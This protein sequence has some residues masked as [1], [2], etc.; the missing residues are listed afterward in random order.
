MRLIP[1]VIVASSL[2]VVPPLWA[3][4]PQDEA[5][6]ESIDKGLSLLEEGARLMLK[7]LR[8][9]LVPMLESL[10]EAIDDAQ[11]YELPE[12]LE[13]GDILIRRKRPQPEQEEGT[14]DL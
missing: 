7:G 12:V 4:E 3:E 9:E 10:S 14:V 11:A 8:G 6:P 2:L 13:N 5:A 1:V